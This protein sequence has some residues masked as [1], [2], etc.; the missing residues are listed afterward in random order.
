MQDSAL[1]IIGLLTFT[2]YEEVQK[3][4]AVIGFNIHLMPRLLFKLFQHKHLAT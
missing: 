2:C 4:V 3:F 1:F